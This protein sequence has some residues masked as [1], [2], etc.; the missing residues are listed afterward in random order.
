MADRTARGNGEQ[1]LVV[2]ELGREVYGVDIAAVQE[3]IR[4]QEITKVPRAPRFVEGVI[5]LRGKVIPVVDLRHRF[6]LDHADRTRASRIVVVDIGDHTIGMVVD[7]VSEV[8]RITD[9]CV[10]PP[11]PVV[12]TLDSD[13]L[14]G[15]AKL[16][17]RLVILL[18]LDQ[19][20]ATDAIRAIERAAA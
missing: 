1:Q 13:Y 8:L 7:G 17:E 20:L 11:S 12:T 4:M 2:F 10:E 19:V 14:R 15:I 3:I 9:D 16:E 18:E 6:G 5:N